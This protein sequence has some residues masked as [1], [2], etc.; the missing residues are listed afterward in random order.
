[1]AGSL[2]RAGCACDL[3][4]TVESGASWNFDPWHEE[5]VVG[6]IGH[7]LHSFY[8]SISLSLN[9]IMLMYF[10]LRLWTKRIENEKPRR[11]AMQ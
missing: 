8:V 6:G 3:D 5:D 1:M 2:P 4:Y 7:I 9:L 10:F 11:W